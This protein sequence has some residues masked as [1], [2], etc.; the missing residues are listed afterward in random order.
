[1]EALDAICATYIG[2]ELLNHLQDQFTGRLGQNAGWQLSIDQTDKY[3]HTLL[4]RYPTSAEDIAHSYVRGHVK[5]ELGWRSVTEP[6]ELRTLKPYIADQFPSAIQ[7]ADVICSVLLPTRTFWEKVTAI[8]AESFK[9][10]VPQFFSRH[11]SDVAAMLQSEIGNAAARDVAMLED[12]RQYKERYYASAR[13]HYD[14][15]IPG[16]LAIVPDD[17][18]V[19]ALAADYR[20]MRMMFFRD[21]PTFG[22]V[23]GRLRELQEQLN[24]K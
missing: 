3:G 19:R 23:M 1:M 22:E 8:H 4:F 6:A 24:G 21:P 10:G 9:D 14:L 17:D 11:Y 15:A 20:E 12:V 7:D 18:K 16:S 13:A 5:L 2:G